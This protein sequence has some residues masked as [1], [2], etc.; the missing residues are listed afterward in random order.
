MEIP[1]L[2][3]ALTAL[4][5]PPGQSHEM[6]RMLHRRAG[7][8]AA[9]GGQTRMQAVAHLLGLMKQGWAAKARGF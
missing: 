9:T 2:A 7:Q 3:E 1:A 5:C 6:A 4:G 8:L